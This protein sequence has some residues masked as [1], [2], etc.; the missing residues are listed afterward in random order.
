[1]VPSIRKTFSRYILIVFLVFALFSSAFYLYLHYRSTQNVRSSVAQL[2]LSRESA[3]IIDSCIISMYSAD[4]HSRLFALTS[5]TT[6]YNKYNRDVHLVDN[7]LKK[8]N[9]GSYKQGIS[10]TGKVN[11]LM[12]EK[13]KKLDDYINLKHLSDSLLVVARKLIVVKS[14]QTAI[15]QEVPV[16]ERTVNRIQIDTLKTINTPV[17]KRKFFGRIFDAFSSKKT[18]QVMQKS[19]AQRKTA[20]VVTQRTESRVYRMVVEE[21]QSKNRKNYQQLFTINDQLRASE[22]EILFINNHLIKQIIQSLQKYKSE[23]QQ[24]INSGKTELD[25]GLQ[26][27]DF[28]YKRLSGLIFFLLSGLVCIILYNIWKIY[29]YQKNLVYHSAFAEHNAA[30]KTSFLAGMSHEIRTPLNSVIGFSE[31][32]GQSKLDDTQR[33]QLDA[34]TNSSKILLD[35]VNQVLDFSKFETGKMV[36]ERAPFIPQDILE[37][38]FSTL[39]IQ[40]VNKGISI[41][42]SF[43]ISPELSV[44]GDALRLKQVLINLLGNAIKFTKEGEVT[45]KATVSSD[46]KDQIRLIVWVKD[47][48]VGI[49]KENVNMIFGEFSQVASAQKDASQKGTGLGLAISKKIIEQQG[50][51]IRVTSEEGKGSVFKFSL[52]MEINH[53][54]ELTKPS[55]IRV[56]N[57]IRIEDKRL[58]IAEDNKLNILL[59]STILKK[60][61]LNFDTAENGVEALE[62]FNQTDYDVILTD[63]EMPEMGGLELTDIIRSSDDAL[64]AAIPIIALTANVFKEDHERYLAAGLDGVILKPFSEQSLLKGITDVLE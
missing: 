34:I 57:P 26:E 37:E 63:I 46:K 14:K 2:L 52:P 55:G 25:N 58:L 4:N 59:L 1:M 33:E 40:A 32:L 28:R 43:D 22:Q 24:H 53:V 31:Q 27:V 7:L 19:L 39:S 36:F 15:P 51:Y 35:I 3:A 62:L 42:K 41:A 29:R 60:W 61:N 18:E 49:S 23:E 13:S 54:K 48:G 44:K 64:K 38:V 45:I 9:S 10:S 8:L 47:T 21:N 50:G 6:Y 20:P 11:H 30:S 56:Q 12:K 16:I 5:D 17:K